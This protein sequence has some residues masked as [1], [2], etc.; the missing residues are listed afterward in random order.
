[1]TKESGNE[2]LES[3]LPI[4]QRA[5]GPFNLDSQII[6]F[7]IHMLMFVKEENIHVNWAFSDKQTKTRRRGWKQ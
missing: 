2:Y 5:I 1:M 3:F 7:L 6:I 4:L